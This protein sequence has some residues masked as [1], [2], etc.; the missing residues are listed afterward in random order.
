MKRHAYR[1]DGDA[2]CKCGQGRAEDM[3]NMMA[4]NKS[5][6]IGFWYSGPV[7]GVAYR[8]RTRLGRTSCWWPEFSLLTEE[9]WTRIGDGIGVSL[10]Q[11]K[12]MCEEHRESRE[13]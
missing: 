12:L 6:G 10:A 1:K 11:A 9:N 4:W 13:E 2:I 3:H 5:S 7:N 8:V